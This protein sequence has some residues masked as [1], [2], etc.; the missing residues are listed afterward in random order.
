MRSLNRQDSTTVALPD[1]MLK[2]YRGCGGDGPD[3]SLKIQLTF[4]LLTNSIRYIVFEDGRSPDQA[5][6]QDLEQLAAGTLRISDLGYFKMTR[7]ATI[8]ARNAYFLSRFNYQTA[9]YNLQGDRVNLLQW[10]NKQSEDL[11]EKS[12]LV[13]QATKLESRL[14]ARRLPQKIADKRRAKAKKK[15]KKRG[16][17]ACPINL[18]LMSWCIFITNVPENKLSALQIAELYPVRWQIELIFKLWKSECGIDKVA[19]KRRERVLC[20]LYAKLIGVV[21]FNFLVGPHRMNADVELSMIKTHRTFKSHA[22]RLALSLSNIE[23]LVAMISQIIRRFFKFGRKN[24]RVKSP[25]TLNLLARE[26]LAPQA[27]NNEPISQVNERVNQINQDATKSNDQRPLIEGL[28]PNAI[29][30]VQPNRPAI[31]CNTNLITNQEDG[32]NLRVIAQKF[33]QPS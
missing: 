25:S 24:K 1:S 30:I 29:K 31:V 28:I 15:A 17:K 14:V 9:L 20:E 18:A 33:V 32:M 8:A 23:Q 12:F 19:G 2:Y 16:K 11:V 13:G 4:D 6:S 27:V 26:I 5:Y 3:S 22:L 7:F 10:L 21:I